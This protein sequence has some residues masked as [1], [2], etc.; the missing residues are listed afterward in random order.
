MAGWSGKLC[1]GGASCEE[2]TGVGIILLRA[3]FL[4]RR[5]S[6]GWLYLCRYYANL[7]GLAVWAV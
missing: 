3:L 7:N 6:L 1:S 5:E 4:T 2:F